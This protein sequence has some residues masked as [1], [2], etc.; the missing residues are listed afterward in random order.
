MAGVLHWIGVFMLFAAAV[1]L[2]TT[3]ISS[4][5]VHDIGILKVTLSNSSNVS[6]GTFGYCVLDV[7]STQKGSDYCSRKSVGYKLADTM[8]SFDGTGFDGAASTSADALTNAMI[9][10]PIACAVTMIAMIM[11]LLP[12]VCGAILGSMVTAVAW[13]LTVVVMAIDFALFGV[14]IIGSDSN[15]VSC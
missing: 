7:A 8:Q 6:F 10:H 9:L 15:P 5:V 3:T 11:A 2:L 1:L 13:I 14:R 12:G 4:P